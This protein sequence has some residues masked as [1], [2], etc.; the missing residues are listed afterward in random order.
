MVWLLLGRCA[1]VA[2]LLW[3]LGCHL[4]VE[5]VGAKRNLGVWLLCVSASKNNAPIVWHYFPPLQECDDVNKFQF[6]PVA[7][8]FVTVEARMKEQIQR[9][10]DAAEVCMRIEEE[11][12]CAQKVA[13][14]RR[15]LESLQ[16]LQRQGNQFFQVVDEAK[17]EEVLK[18]EESQTAREMGQAEGIK[19]N[20]R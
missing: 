6:N 9:E 1:E 5:S 17:K 3:S 14:Q 18:E 19:S 12:R 7:L 11:I 10:I 16:Q 15:G 4:L 13:Q 8:E 20:C 2:G